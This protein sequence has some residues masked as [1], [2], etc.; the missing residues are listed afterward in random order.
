ML[1]QFS[2][3]GISHYMA[4]FLFKLKYHYKNYYFLIS[5]VVSCHYFISLV[6]PCIPDFCSNS[7]RKPRLPVI[8]ENHLKIVL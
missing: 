6:I 4:R 1:L 7:P 2:T 8:L 5:L 3:I